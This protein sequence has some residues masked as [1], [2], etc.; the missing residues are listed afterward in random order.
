MIQNPVVFVFGM[1]ITCVYYV[2][3][4]PLPAQ[5]GSLFAPS[6]LAGDGPYQVV[7]KTSHE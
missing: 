3:L 4:S 6:W 1:L 5:I 2:R 7:K